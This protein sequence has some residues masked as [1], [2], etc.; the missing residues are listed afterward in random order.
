MKPDGNI[1]VPW[2]LH[3]YS[4]AEYARDNDSRKSVTGY[5]VLI[6]GAVIN[7]RS[8]SQKTVTLTVTEAEY[9]SITEIYCEILFSMRFYFLWELLL[10]TPLPCML[11]ALE[12]YYCQITY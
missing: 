6:N 4:D 8:Q 5:I 1:K 12:L 7:W 9:S 11:I 10:N 3:G 2:E